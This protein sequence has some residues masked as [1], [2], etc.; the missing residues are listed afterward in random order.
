MLTLTVKSSILKLF[1]TSENNLEVM[2]FP[3][4]RI[5]KYAWWLLSYYTRYSEIISKVKSKYFSAL[6]WQEN[7]Y[8]MKD[9]GKFQCFLWCW[10]GP[11]KGRM[12][13]PQK[14]FE[15]PCWASALSSVRWSL[16]SPVVVAL[17]HWRCQ[18]ISVD[19]GQS[20][21]DLCFVLQPNTPR[22][23]IIFFTPKPAPSP[24]SSLLS[25]KSS[26]SC[27]PSLGPAEK[28]SVI[29]NLLIL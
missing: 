24:N 26:S 12:R 18:F 19:K 28:S 3:F 15:Q 8:R 17:S 21:W 27:H 2:F 22:I 5:T 25:T 16:R 11:S 14:L 4:A 10:M 13:R 23:K 1:V 9:V 20:T 6:F 29:Q 7:I